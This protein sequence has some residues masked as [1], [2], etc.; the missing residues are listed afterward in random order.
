[1]SL[2][3]V[4]RALITYVDENVVET[5]NLIRRLVQ[6]DTVNPYSGDPVKQGSP[7]GDPPN[8]GTPST[9]A[10]SRESGSDSY[11]ELVGQE[12]VAT[13]LRG[14]GANVRMFE[15]PP[16]TFERANVIGPKQRSWVNRPNVVAEWVF[17]DGDGP[18][19][20]VMGHIDTV[21][22]LGMDDPFSGELVDGRVHGRGS[23]DDKGGLAAGLAAVRAVVD[24]A[25][26]LCGRLTFLS[27]V[28]EECNGSGAGIIA[29][30]LE[31]IRADSAVSLDGMAGE[32]IR[33]CQG[34][35]TVQIEVHGQAG[36][37]AFGNGVNAVEKAMHIA[38]A[39]LEWRDQREADR[40]NCRVNLG[41]LHGGTLPAVIP[42]NAVLGMNIVYDFDEAEHAR[43]ETGVWGGRMV[44]DEINEVVRHTEQADEWLAAHPSDLTWVKDLVPY[45]MPPDSRIVTDFAQAARDALG[46]E[47]TVEK[48]VAWTDSCWLSVL[49]DT[50]I[51]S[52]G[53]AA[54]DVVHGPNEYVEIDDILNSAKAVA[55][56]IHRQ[57]RR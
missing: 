47:P 9:S 36:H 2:S 50:P 43:D 14:L 26:D 56:Y 41:I 37:A 1:M 38:G 48:M 46:S 40:P 34:C 42:D 44:W 6:I 15:P 53:P 51:V 54:P 11:G 45:D 28:D 31:G 13:E 17:G 18:S 12:F 52:F 24:H 16:D 20:I 10:R 5:T 57:L 55:L 25:A 32:L 23:S 19:V 27:V 35:V 22:V 7:S 21:G 4:E 8:E 39:I 49:A 3:D 33:G 29:C 30:A